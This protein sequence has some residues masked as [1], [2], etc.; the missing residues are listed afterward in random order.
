MKNKFPKLALSI[1]FKIIFLCCFWDE[2]INDLKTGFLIVYYSIGSQNPLCVHW[3][4]FVKF[5]KYINVLKLCGLGKFWK[6]ALQFCWFL[7]PDH[8]VHNWTTVLTLHFW[9][10]M[11]CIGAASLTCDVMYRFWSRLS[12]KRSYPFS[13][14]SPGDVSPCR[15]QRW[16]LWFVP[17]ILSQAKESHRDFNP[18]MEMAIHTM[19]LLPLLRWSLMVI[20]MQ[21]NKFPWSELSIGAGGGGDLAG[22][23]SAHIH[24]VLFVSRSHVMWQAHQLLFSPPGRTGLQDASV[25]RW[26]LISHRAFIPL[27]YVSKFAFGIFQH[28]GSSCG[29]FLSA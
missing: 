23:S 24:P 21:G 9:F 14:S 20:S 13:S 27:A 11:C 1:F 6:L 4:T 16:V 25:L 3:R 10:G 12:C 8:V 18:V 5:Q 29:S 28:Y 26:K 17:L 19:F 2:T 22:R 7:R 15:P